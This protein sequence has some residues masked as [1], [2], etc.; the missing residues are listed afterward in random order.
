[1]KTIPFIFFKKPSQQGL[2]LRWASIRGGFLLLKRQWRTQEMHKYTK[3]TL[4]DLN[5]LD[6]TRLMLTGGASIWG[7]RLFEYTITFNLSMLMV[8]SLYDQLPQADEMM[9]WQGSESIRVVIDMLYIDES[10]KYWYRSQCRTQLWV[11]C[12]T[13]PASIDTA[14]KPL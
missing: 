10:R 11:R 14:Y 13:Y 4:K 1:M 2:Y 3:T 8:G 5:F 12:I 7:R 9:R 6:F